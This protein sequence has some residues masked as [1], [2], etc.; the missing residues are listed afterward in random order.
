MLLVK[1]T[2]KAMGDKPV[3]VV[4]CLDKPA[5]V[6]EFEPWADAILVSFGVQN[7]AVLDIVSGKC[8][9]SGLLPMQREGTA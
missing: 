2:K 9:P 8:E 5:V 7:Q 4:L 1:E 6:R 3:V